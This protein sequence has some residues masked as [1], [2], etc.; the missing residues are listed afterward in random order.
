MG[1]RQLSNFSSPSRRH[2]SALV[3]LLCDSGASSAKYANLLY[4]VNFRYYDMVEYLLAGG[5]D[6]YWQ[7][8]SLHDIVPMMYALWQYWRYD[9][10]RIPTDAQK[11]PDQR[12]A[13]ILVAVATMSTAS[14]ATTTTTRIT[15]S[16][17]LFGPRIGIATT[18]DTAAQ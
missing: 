15:A 5:A 11:V 6:M 4:A 8:G 10:S 1:P 3:K 14:R 7:G 9:S 13:E 12:M 2:A 18:V 16:A 17:S